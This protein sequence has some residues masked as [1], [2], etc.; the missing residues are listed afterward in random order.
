MVSKRSACLTAESPLQAL[1][2][3]HLLRIATQV[4]ML[5]L[6]YTLDDWLLQHSKVCG[7][8]NELTIGQFSRDRHF[9]LSLPAARPG[10][11]GKIENLGTA[12][13]IAIA[14]T[15]RL[16]QQIGKATSARG[17]AVSP[18]EVASHRR[19]S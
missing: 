4:Q 13:R 12:C 14:L 6:L 8:L 19:L 5:A 1:R 11:E 2:G 18:I 9:E 16:K 10:H 3:I 7:D 17:C 15:S